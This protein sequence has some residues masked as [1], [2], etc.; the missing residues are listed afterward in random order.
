MVFAALEGGSPQE[1]GPKTDKPAPKWPQTLSDHHK[2][3]ASSKMQY[4]GT[5]HPRDTFLGSRHHGMGL[6]IYRC[7][8]RPIWGCFGPHLASFGPRLDRTAE[9]ALERLH[10]EWSQCRRG[11]QVNIFLGWIQGRGGGG[12]I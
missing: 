4:T 1:S 2:Q 6:Y 7:L 8:F 11:V 5:R 10:V 3:V 9:Q 12:G